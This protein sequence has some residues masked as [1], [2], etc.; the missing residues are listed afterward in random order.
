MYF[1]KIISIATFE[2]K[3]YETQVEV[4]PHFLPKFTEIPSSIEQ[5]DKEETILLPVSW[6]L[7]LGSFSGE[8]GLFKYRLMSLIS[9]F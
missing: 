7:I 9:S 1:V 6:R 8:N 4:A 5:V 3:Q 2:E